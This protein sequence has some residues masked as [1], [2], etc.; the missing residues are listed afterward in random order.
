MRFPLRFCFQLVPHELKLIKRR[1]FKSSR[2]E[3]SSKE[4]TTASTISLFSLNGFRFWLNVIFRLHYSAR[5]SSAPLCA[6]MDSNTNVFPIV[7]CVYNVGAMERSKKATCSIFHDVYCSSQTTDSRAEI[8]PSRSRED[9]EK[10]CRNPRTSFR[11]WDLENISSISHF[12]ELRHKK[13]GFKHSFWSGK[14]RRGRVCGC[15]PPKSSPSVRMFS[16][17]PCRCVRRDFLFLCFPFRC[18]YRIPFP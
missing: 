5:L 4:R 18:V 17:P 12:S 13:C 9:A 15:F 8:C 11:W 1:G 7:C 16:P 6:W 10:R 2:T 3:A 14:H